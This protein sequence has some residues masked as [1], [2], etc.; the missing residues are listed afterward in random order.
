MFFLNKCPKFPICQTRQNY[1]LN[2]LSLFKTRNI[3]ERKSKKQKTKEPRKTTKL[4]KHRT[5]EDPEKSEFLENLENSKT[6]TKVQLRIN[7][8][9]FRKLE[10]HK[11]RQ[12]HNIL[13]NQSSKKNGNLAKPEKSTHQTKYNIHK[14]R[15][16]GKS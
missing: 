3:K 13:K 7:S 5:S 10:I 16:S 9:Q 8:K 1:R 2:N 6:I 12:I 4:A 15:Q 11:A 14:A